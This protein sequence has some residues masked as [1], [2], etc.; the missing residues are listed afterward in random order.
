MNPTKPRALVVSAASL[1][2]AGMMLSCGLNA[3]EIERIDLKNFGDYEPNLGEFVTLYDRDVTGGTLGAISYGEIGWDI[4]KAEAPGIIVYNNTPAYEPG[5]IIAD[6]VMALRIDADRQ[7]NGASQP[8]A[9]YKMRATAIG[10]IDMVFRVRLLDANAVILDADGFP[11]AADQDVTRNIYRMIG[12]LSND[13]G[14]RLGGF[15]V[16]VGFGLGADFYKSKAS[17]GLKIGLHE[18]G[19]TDADN[20]KDDEIAEFLDDL[21]YGPADAAH[22]WGFF[23]SSR[24]G[25]AVDTAALE[26]EEDFFG[27]IGISSNYSELFGKWLPLTL[28]PQG[29]FY[30][31]DGDPV[32]DAAVTAWYDGTRWIQYVVDEITGVRTAIYPDAGQI[33]DWEATPPSVY[34]D[35]GVWTEGDSLTAGGILYAT[36]DAAAGVYVLAD[37]TTRVTNDEMS[38]RIAAAPDQLERRPGYLVGPIEGL[39]NLNLNYFI[40]VANPSAWPTYANGEATFTLRITPLNENVTAL[41]APAS[42]TP[43]P[44]SR[45]GCVVGGDGHPDTTLPALLAAGLGFFGWRR[46]KAGK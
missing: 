15:T 2:L 11:L 42:E 12:M 17:D 38:A 37:G 33:A 27:S 1:A 30:D 19:A 46:F 29:W 44:S 22:D 41:P 10:P 36:W 23:S 9:R 43:P 16:Q 28:V 8:P 21:F 5:Q 35:D 4:L 24:A 34:A 7:C 32:T 13:T 26:T 40:E 18:E 20:L 39:A 14:K 3:G 6:C 31:R 25:L 45:G